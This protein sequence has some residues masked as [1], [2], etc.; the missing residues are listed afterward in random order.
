MRADA[1][2]RSRSAT[3]ALSRARREMRRA[4][5]RSAPALRGG[6]TWGAGARAPD[7]SGL[8]S[9]NRGCELVDAVCAL[10]APNEVAEQRRVRAI[11]ADVCRDPREVEQRP[12][13]F[14]RE[15]ELGGVDA[16]CFREGVARVA[17]PGIHGG[18]RH[19][20]ATLVLHARET[21]LVMLD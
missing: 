10:R 18:D 14:I 5:R 17:Q 4:T 11:A 9:G 3:P 1:R 7:A 20:S 8:R 21:L 6:R 2:A 13:L 15:L 16:G 12:S 19:T